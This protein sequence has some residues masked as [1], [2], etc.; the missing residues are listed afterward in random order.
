MTPMCNHLMEKLRKNLSFS[1][2]P[3]SHLTW[4]QMDSYT[5]DQQLS[6]WSV[7]SASF[8]IVGYHL[9]CRPL[10]IWLWRPTGIDRKHDFHMSSKVC[11]FLSPVVLLPANTKDHWSAS[12][13]PLMVS[14]TLFR[15]CYL[16]WHKWTIRLLFKA[17]SLSLEVELMCHLKS[18]Q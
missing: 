2:M 8:N 15:H 10:K 3:E 1:L 14:N 13:S 9:T 18:A 11:L 12:E 6:C 5:E 17:T 4:H 16:M 7:F